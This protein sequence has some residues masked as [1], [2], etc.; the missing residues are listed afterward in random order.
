MNC[1]EEALA[2]YSQEIGLR[3]TMTLRNLIDSHR[4]LRNI[5]LKDVKEKMNEVEAA[6]KRAYADAKECATTYDWFSK[7]R[8]KG[9]TI[10]ELVQLLYEE[11]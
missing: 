10:G 5:S 6:R 9:L 1:Y 3:E 8:L 7:E 4:T 2:E 11:G